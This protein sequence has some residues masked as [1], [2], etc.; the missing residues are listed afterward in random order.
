MIGNLAR[1]SEQTEN[2]SDE[3]GRSLPFSEDGEKVLCSLLLSSA[4]RSG[5][6]PNQIAPGGFL[7]AGAP[8]SLQ[9]C[10]RTGGLEPAYRFHYI[11]ITLKQALK[12]RA[13]LDEIGGPE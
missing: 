2:S 4:R 10:G 3:V 11:I 5:S 8:N 13:Q 7:H 1:R 9:S 6:L 12:D